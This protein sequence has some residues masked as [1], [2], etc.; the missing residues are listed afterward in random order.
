MLMSMGDIH[1]ATVLSFGLQWECKLR[2][3]VF[4]VLG[5]EPVQVWGI[6]V[7]ICIQTL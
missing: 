6:H 1:M 2:Y 4:S 7:C 5:M 3:F